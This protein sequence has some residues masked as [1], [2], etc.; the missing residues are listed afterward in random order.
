MVLTLGTRAPLEGL[1]MFEPNFFRKPYSV[2]RLSDVFDVCS[3]RCRLVISRFL[4]ILKPE[5]ENFVEGGDCILRK[6]NSFVD[7]LMTLIV[8]RL[9]PSLSRHDP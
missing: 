5:F 1:G 2:Y 3:K 4:C 6:K 7:G 9:L 8:Y